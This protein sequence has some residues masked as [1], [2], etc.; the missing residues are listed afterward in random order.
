MSTGNWRTDKPSDDRWVEVWHHT[1]SCKAQ[2]TGS[3]WLDE[4]GRQLI[5]VTHWRDV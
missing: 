3:M 1:V 4:Q 2:W 5:G